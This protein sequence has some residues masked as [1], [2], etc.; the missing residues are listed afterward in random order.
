MADVGKAGKVVSRG[1]Y[2][3]HEGRIGIDQSLWL[4]HAVNLLDAGRR[5]RYVLEDCL[6]DHPFKRS[7]F[8]RDL[9]GIAD[10]RRSWAEVD[11]GFD[12]LDG[13]MLQNLVEAG[14]NGCAAE[15]QNFWFRR[16]S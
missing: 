3:L 1:V 5:I 16:D 13:F 4:Q 12:E 6:H 8:K 15:N 10:Q 2:L 14:A 7:L 11:V 9:M